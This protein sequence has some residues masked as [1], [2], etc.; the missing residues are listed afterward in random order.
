MCRRHDDR[1]GP[2]AMRTTSRND[3]ATVTIAI[4][5]V[6]AVLVG[7]M[8]WAG[9]WTTG[10]SYQVTA[11]VP[12][13]KT[14]TPDAHVMIAGLEVGRVTSIRR[15]GLD[16]IVGLRIDNGP[17]PIPVD[18]RIAVRLRSLLGESYVEVFLGRSRQTI[19]NGGSLAVSQADDYVD[20]DQILSVLKGQTRTRAQQTIQALGGAVRDRGPQLNQVLGSGSN[21]IT[22]ALPVASTLAGQH[23]HVTQL[24]KNLDDVMASVSQRSTAIAQFARGMRVTFESI[25]AR[26]SQLRDVLDLLPS[27][28]GQV[29]S[30]SRLLQT[31]T[32]RMSPVLDNLGTALTDLAPAVN[33]LAPA[34]TN[35]NQ[36]VQALGAAADPLRT[37][38]RAVRQV[39]QPAAAAMPQ[40]H[41]SLC[42]LNPILK[43]A[44]P[45]GPE[46]GAFF[47]NFGS[48]G[49]WYDATAH[50]ARA[51]L[52]LSP[53]ALGGVTPP[54]VA[55]AVN[56]LENIGI[57]STLHRNGYN[58]FPKPGQ[59]GKTTVGAGILGPDYAK[60]LP[61]PHVLAD[62]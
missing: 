13:A 8:L 16:A 49:N 41:A 23:D 4:A 3:I 17:T 1:I 43:Y 22:D 7:L 31:L 37:M 39:T 15:N 11:F 26:D 34:A 9:L 40:V 27:T 5:F 48:G 44:A 10:S 42:Q 35:G 20:L 12:D 38:L 58:P 2:D 14:L 24:V 6:V 52:I 32:P 47:E 21:L 46:M 28:L 51:S 57:A 53:A 50:A 29:R 45:Y 25:A 62:C 60:G 33:V 59:A 61:Y 55:S 54:A 30:T 36:L 18:S 56:F 19:R